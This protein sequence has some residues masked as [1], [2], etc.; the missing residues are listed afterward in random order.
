[1]NANIPAIKGC[2]A[3][4]E[5]PEQAREEL[6]N[7]FEMIYQEYIEIG[8]TLPKDVNLIIAHAC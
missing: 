7:V 1:L 4:G 5:T 8:K 3:W 2:H 6:Q